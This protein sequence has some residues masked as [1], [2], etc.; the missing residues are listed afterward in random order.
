MSSAGAATL[1]ARRMTRQLSHGRLRVGC[2]A[3]PHESFHLGQTP[4]LVQLL[5]RGVPR[6]VLHFDRGLSLLLGRCAGRLF[7][8]VGGFAFLILAGHREFPRHP[9]G[10]LSFDPRTFGFRR[11][12][13][14]PGSL[15][16]CSDLPFAFDL[17]WRI[18]P[19]TR[20]GFPEFLHLPELLGSV[21]C[22][23]QLC[24][25]LLPLRLLLL[26]LLTSLF[27]DAGQFELLALLQRAPSRPNLAGIGSRYDLVCELIREVSKQSDDE[28]LRFFRYRLTLDGSQYMLVVLILIKK[29]SH[30]P[31]L[32]FVFSSPDSARLFFDGVGDTA[33]FLDLVELNPIL[34][35]FVSSRVDDV[36]ILPVAEESIGTILEDS[37]PFIVIESV[38]ITVIAVTRQSRPRT[39]EANINVWV[40]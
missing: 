1:N 5:E 21:A 11:L 35:D 4:F 6:L 9:F 18:C 20:D 8:G 17:L 7:P 34:P 38:A 23:R 39:Y 26:S 13:C 2:L 12:V 36:P 24:D 31:E 37:P 19:A 3:Q 25:L 16:L 40:T 29:L 27:A 28:F 22:L 30:R 15:G 32:L 10:G 14:L 33:I